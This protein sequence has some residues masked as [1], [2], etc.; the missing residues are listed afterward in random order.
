LWLLQLLQ[1]VAV[2]GVVDVKRL[3]AVAAV[4]VGTG[5]HA[6]IA[7]VDAEEIHLQIVMKTGRKGGAVVRE[8]ATY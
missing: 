2:A 7:V 1:T 5:L 4:V 3:E 8:V 6:L